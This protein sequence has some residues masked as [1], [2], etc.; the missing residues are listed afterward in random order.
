MYSTG[1]F[2]YNCSKLTLLLSLAASIVTF[3]QVRAAQPIIQEYDVPKGSGPH[4]VAPA[5]DGK[6]WY[7]AQRSGELGVLDPET[8][9]THHIKL[10]PGSAPHGVIV[11]PD[12]AA[13][14]TDGGQN[15]IVRVDPTTETV[16]VF[17]LPSQRNA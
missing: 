6:V 16:K 3:H 4:D 11:G 14:I 9:K 7:T 2:W 8:G 12:G 1:R 17:P 5:P 10:G 15:A 13:W